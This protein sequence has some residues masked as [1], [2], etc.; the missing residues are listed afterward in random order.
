M[1]RPRKAPAERRDVRI[2]P[3]LTAAELDFIEAQA[4]AAGIDPAEYARR[5]MLGRRVA[6]ARSA[7]DDR[8]ILELNRVGV[9]LNQIARAVNMDRDLDADFCAVLA[10]LRTVLE[11]VAGRG[12]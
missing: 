6:A 3:R 7:A 11:R 9:N 8:L 10:E 5:R 2:A 12:S 4:A 1:A